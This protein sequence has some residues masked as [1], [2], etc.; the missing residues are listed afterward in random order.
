MKMRQHNIYF[1]RGGMEPFGMGGGMDMGRGGMP[2]RGGMMRGGMRGGKAFGGGMGGDME[3]GMGRGGAF[4]RG[5]SMRCVF[6]FCF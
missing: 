4:G 3:P 5:G 1:P 6:C 2:P